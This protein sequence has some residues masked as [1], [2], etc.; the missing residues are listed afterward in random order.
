MKL[1]RFYIE[2][3]VGNANQIRIVSRS[4]LWQAINVLRVGLNDSVKIFD[5]SG[6]D[7]EIVIVGYDNYTMICDVKKR[8]V[9]KVLPKRE[10]YLFASIVKKD[11]FE[12]I[13]EKATELGV[14]HIIPVISARSEKKDLN[15]ARLKK[16]GDY[17]LTAG[18]S[19]SRIEG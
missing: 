5:N 11:K 1:H 14:T 12:W 17:P 10:V 2:E 18:I 3:T 8:I 4:V 16:I 13:V 7:Y 9:N 15:I 6:F 19:R